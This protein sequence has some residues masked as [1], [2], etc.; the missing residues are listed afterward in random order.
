VLG[1]L[2]FA[3]NELLRL[4]EWRLLRWQKS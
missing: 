1:L 4:V 2:G 3:C